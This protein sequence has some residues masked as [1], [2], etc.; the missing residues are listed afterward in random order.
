M[1]SGGTTTA[2]LKLEGIDGRAHQGWSLWLNLNQHGKTY[3][4]QIFLMTDQA[5]GLSGYDFWW[6]MAVGGAWVDLSSVD[7][8]NERDYRQLHTID[9]F[10]FTIVLIG[11]P[12]DFSRRKRVA[13]TGP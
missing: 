9:R 4:D 11:T 2:R 8:A 12:C 7:S 10:L 5:I 13:I 6:C 3:Q 1:G